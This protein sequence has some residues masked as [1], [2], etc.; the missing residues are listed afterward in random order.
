MFVWMEHGNGKK[1]IICSWNT[2]NATV[3]CHK[4]SIVNGKFVCV[5]GA[6]KW[7]VAVADD[8]R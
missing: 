6:L 3:E 1:W 4:M 7:Y 8:W 5:F 2:S